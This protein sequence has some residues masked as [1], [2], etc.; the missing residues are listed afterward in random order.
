MV[1]IHFQ[2][3]RYARGGISYQRYAFSLFSRFLIFHCNASL[4]FPQA[5]PVVGPVHAFFPQTN[6]RTRYAVSSSAESCGSLMDFRRLRRL[7][8][9]ACLSSCSSIPESRFL[10]YLQDLDVGGALSLLAFVVP[11]QLPVPQELLE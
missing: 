8:H 7:L 11:S 9:L 1:F 5:K 10:L 3:A 2:F 6:E 4:V